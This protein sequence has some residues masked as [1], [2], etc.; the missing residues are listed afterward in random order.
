[1][2][3]VQD[4]VGDEGYAA[5]GTRI[6]VHAMGGASVVRIIGDLDLAVADRLRTTLEPA[7][8]RCPWVIVDLGGAGAVDSVGLGVLVA[9]RQAARRE[10]GDVLLAATP[11][12]V[13]SVLRAARLDAVFTTFDTVPRAIT[14]ALAR[15]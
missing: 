8:A 7:I 10:D 4:R 2:E 13:T 12:F 3:V 5:D 6:T 14:F 15:G 11:P 1:M 9:A